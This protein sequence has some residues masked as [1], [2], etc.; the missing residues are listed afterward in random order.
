MAGKHK[1]RHRREQQEPEE[2]LPGTAGMAQGQPAADVEPGEEKPEQPDEL[3]TGPEVLEEQQ[4][5]PD[6]KDNTGGH[7]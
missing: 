7:P 2:P 5:N 1:G 6:L 3:V 4:Q